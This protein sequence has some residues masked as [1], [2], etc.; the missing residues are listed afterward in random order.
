MCGFRATAEPDK[1]IAT[2]AGR[3]HGVAELQQLRQAGLSARMVE[4]R[5]QAGRLHRKYRGVYA[6]GHRG[7]SS[8]GEWMAAVLACGEGA[9]LSHRSAA[10][11]WALLPPLSW[12]IH[13]TV[14]SDCGRKKHHGIQLHRS[15]SLKE[16][17]CTRRNGIPVTTA[18]RTV[19]D[20]KRVTTPAELRRAIHQADYLG[21]PLS[22]NTD[23]TR[24]DLER[25]FLR[26]CR[27]HRLP[28]PEVNV[29]I[30]AFT[31]D[32]YWPAY[33]LA[34][35]TDGWRAH[36]GR[37]AFIDDR[38]REAFLR[39]RGIDLM[40]FSDEQVRGDARTVAALLRRKLT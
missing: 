30:G 23:G 36:R 8:E 31:I 26:L 38:A 2:I 15:S 34:V 39:Q 11:L 17:D 3:Q 35:E 37:Q 9:V 21:L 13:V 25:A 24:S 1:A 20:L 16:R 18:A 22:F 14:P 19:L 32:F 7:L 27:R 10:E 29:K 4:Y 33:Q 40:R 5:A 6:V 12:P 28:A